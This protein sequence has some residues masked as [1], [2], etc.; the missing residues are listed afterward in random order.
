MLPMERNASP[1]MSCPFQSGLL[2]SSA[3]YLS[4]VGS[5]S[6]EAGSTTDDSRY[7]GCGLTVL[8][9]IQGHLGFLNA[10]GRGGEPFLG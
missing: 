10:P 1:T 6:G 2:A 5:S 3:I 7:E 4:H 9:S 8:T